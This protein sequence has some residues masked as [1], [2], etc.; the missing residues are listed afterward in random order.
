RSFNTQFPGFATDVHGLV[1]EGDSVGG[2]RYYVDCVRE[3]V[4]VGVAE[5]GVAAVKAGRPARRTGAKTAA[6]PG[7]VQKAPKARTAKAAQAA[8]TAEIAQTAAAPAAPKPAGK[9]ARKTA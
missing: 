1:E 4:D 7:P 2:S 5:A 9:R 6:A 3:A 8:Q